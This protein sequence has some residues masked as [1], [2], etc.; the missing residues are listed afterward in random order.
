MVGTQQDLSVVDALV[1]SGLCNSRG[2]AKKLIEQGAVLLDGEVVG[3]PSKLVETEHVLL[4][5]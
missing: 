1:E 3:D 2:E 5:K 4:Q